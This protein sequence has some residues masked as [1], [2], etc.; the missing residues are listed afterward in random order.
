MEI[1]PR[2][3]EADE[4]LHARTND[5]KNELTQRVERLEKLLSRGV[6]DRR[7]AQP[8]D[9]E[10]A[11]S[12]SSQGP[13]LYSESPLGQA[14]PG[15]D[16]L[17]SPA[18]SPDPS[19][20]ASFGKLH[21]A[22][23]QLGDINSFQGIPLFSPE[24][25]RWIEERTGSKPAFP[26]LVAPL[27]QNQ[28][29]VAN[30]VAVASTTGLGLPPRKVAD[31]YFHLFR[32]TPLNLAFPIVRIASFQDTI[33]LAYSQPQNTKSVEVLDAQGCVLC[34]IGILHFFEGNIEDAPVDGELCIAQAQQMMP[35]ILLQSTVTNLQVVLMLVSFTPVFQSTLSSKQH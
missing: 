34:F 26:S 4:P 21:F 17:P 30:H 18:Y 29:H 1:S 27:W 9:P 5:S 31:A 13:S 8:A 25:R 12:K 6:G 16:H 23:Y 20:T 28:Q 32:S 11:S 10:S 7:S 3:R 35:R 33:D 24:G 22:G 14:S 2:G 19:P 15:I